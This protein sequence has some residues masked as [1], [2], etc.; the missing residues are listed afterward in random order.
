MLRPLMHQPDQGARVLDGVAVPVVVE[1]RPHRFRAARFNAFGPYRQLGVG[2]VMAVP[3][4]ESVKANVN[5]IG[6]FDQLVRQAG[7]AAR[8][9]DRAGIAESVVPRL[10]PPAFMPEFDNVAPRMIELVQNAFQPSRRVV[11]AWRKLK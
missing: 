3:V 5:V 2:V 6:C 8:A 11:E 7:T 10:V 1:I 9:E 4:L